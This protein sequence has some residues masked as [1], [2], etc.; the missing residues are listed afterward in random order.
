MT[1]GWIAEEFV[2]D[3]VLKDRIGFRFCLPQMRRHTEMVI[4]KTYSNLKNYEN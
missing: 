1:E 3:G 2:R 4:V